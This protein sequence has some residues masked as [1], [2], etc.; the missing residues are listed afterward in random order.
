MIS[1]YHILLRG[2][3]AT[4][5]AFWVPAASGTEPAPVLRV[6]T[7]STVLTEIA[8]E[9]G[10]DR[11]AVF[12]LVRPDVDPHSFEPSPGDVAVLARA[13][14]VLASGLGLE[15]YLDRLVANA[16]VEGRI[17]SVGDHLP[18]KLSAHPGANPQPGILSSDGE[19]D[20][21]WWH[22]IANMR[23]ATD[24]V[25]MEYSRLRP[26]SAADFARRA[27]AYERR[28]VALQ[29]WTA[30]EVARLPP[31]ARQLVTSHD[32][33]G[34]LARDYGFTVHS[35]CGLSPDAELNARDLARLIGLMRREHIKAVFPESTVNPRLVR[36]LVEETGAKIGTP[37]YADGLGGEG[38]DA[39]TY[40][41]MYRHNVSAIVS[42]LAAP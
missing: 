36:T 5:L 14:L 26:E 35:L 8:R 42:A 11:V 29:D 27:Q 19:P 2:F 20:P 32:A 38:S 33:F 21:H 16:G 6:A 30:Q 34:Y 17:L 10:G 22:S 3:L 1:N 31:A 23:F 12:G 37:L 24:L 9:V 39:A 18:S 13:D 40:E 7:V 4:A 41:A 28:L 15:P 25:R